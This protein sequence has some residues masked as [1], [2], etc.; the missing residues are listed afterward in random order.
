MREEL[1]RINEA[2]NKEIEEGEERDIEW[3]VG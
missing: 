1:E 3:F 2:I